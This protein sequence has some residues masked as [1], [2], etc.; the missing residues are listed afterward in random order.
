[1]VAASRHNTHLQ[2]TKTKE[3]LRPLLQPCV[4]ILTMNVATASRGWILD[5]FNENVSASQVM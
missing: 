1:M 5:L 2:Q 4:H 3:C